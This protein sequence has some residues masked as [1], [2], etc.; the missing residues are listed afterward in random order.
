M[1]KFITNLEANA[2]Y[3]NIKKGFKWENIPKFAVITGENGS[4]K[5][6]LLRQ[7]YNIKVNQNA[8]M[9]KI[10]NYDTI[11]EIYK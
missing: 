9:L 10:F 3:E 5:T 8:N 6:A 1:E 7:I 2:N 11:A 4:G